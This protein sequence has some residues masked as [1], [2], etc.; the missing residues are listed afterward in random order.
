MHNMSHALCAYLGN[1]RGYTYIYEAVA[2]YDIRYVAY[3]ALSEM[4]VAISAENDIQ[5]KPLF[6]HAENLLYRFGNTA[7]GDTVARVGK[8]TI[9]KLGDND[10][11]VGA[12]KLS[13]QHGIPCHSICIGVAASLLFAPEGDVQSQEV[14]D[15][16]LANGALAAL[17][18]YAQLEGTEAELIVKLYDMLKS[19]RQLNTL[20]RMCDGISGAEIRT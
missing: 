11:L 16:A 9:R 13:I 12:L 3:K 17:K 4:A 18:R 19:G 15:Y 20:I 6:E 14:R 5:I 10:R 8:D 2:D 7:L 1:L